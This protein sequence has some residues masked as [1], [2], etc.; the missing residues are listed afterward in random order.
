MTARRTV[1]CAW[2]IAAA[3]LPIAAQA[4]HA[5]E[6]K[7]AA[8]VTTKAGSDKTATSTA[9]TAGKATPSAAAPRKPP[10]D[11]SL[12]SALERL[13]QRI[14]QELD[15]PQTGRTKQTGQRSPSPARAST[16]APPVASA[17]IRLRWRLNLT[18]PAALDDQAAAANEDRIALA[19]H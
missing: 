11:T 1:A 16:P 15:T 17:R 10:V 5:S 3:L 14:K 8:T 18:W 2:T 13:N 12:K 7:A 6:T 19:W 4:Q 9:D